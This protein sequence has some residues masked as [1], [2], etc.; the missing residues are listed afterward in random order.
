[1]PVQVPHPAK[2]WPLLS[3]SPAFGG[4]GHSSFSFRHPATDST[5]LAPSC[6]QNSR[7]LQTNATGRQ[8]WLMALRVLVMPIQPAGNSALLSPPMHFRRGAQ[9]ME[10]PPVQLRPP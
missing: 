3:Y 1:M 2:S 9:W 8:P 4:P 10:A 6:Q 7:G 5:V